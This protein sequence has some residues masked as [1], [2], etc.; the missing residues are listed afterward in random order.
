MKNTIFYIIIIALISVL[1]ISYPAKSQEVVWD[2]VSC[3]QNVGVNGIIVCGNYTISDIQFSHAVKGVRNLDGA[4][5]PEYTITPSIIFNL[6]KDSSVVE[7]SIVLTA[8][9]NTYIDKDKIINILLAGITDGNSKDWIYEYYNPKVTIYVYFRKIPQFTISMTSD[10]TS[11]EYGINKNILLNYSIKNTG[12]VDAKKSIHVVL[13]TSGL[14]TNSQKDFEFCCLA[15]NEIKYFSA[16]LD[17][18]KVDN[19]T[20]YTFSISVGTNDDISQKQFITISTYSAQVVK[21]LQ[22]IFVT[23][24]VPDR[25][26]ASDNATVI[27]SID[28]SG[29]EDIR[30]IYVYD[31]LGNV[32]IP[33]SDLSWQYPILKSGNQIV[34]MYPV[35]VNKI[36][37]YIIPA[38]TVKYDYIGQQQT[39]ISNTVSIYTIDVPSRDRKL[40]PIYTIITPTSTPI[41]NSTPEITSVSEP[42]IMPAETTETHVVAANIKTPTPTVVPIRPPTQSGFE[43]ILLFIVIIFIRRITK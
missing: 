5:Q 35:V 17:V 22:R 12:Q 41:L 28:N 38:A 25:I 24:Y 29:I 36:G 39:I 37:S 19:S 4:I 8:V 13:N 11:Y 34:I 18:P 7:N 14:L 1:S 9:D 30:S 27:I 32:L 2:S 6:Y 3:S 31:D 15:V 23:K 20:D 10:S 16:T 40:I 33:Y 21:T 43:G 42:T 26:Y